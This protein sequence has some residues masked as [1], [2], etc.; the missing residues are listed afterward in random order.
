MARMVQPLDI[1]SDEDDDSSNAGTA[2]ASGTFT[3]SAVC[4]IATVDNSILPSRRRVP[5]GSTALAVTPRPRVPASQTGSMLAAS[6]QKRLSSFS[7]EAQSSGGAIATCAMCFGTS[8]A[9]PSAVQHEIY[10]MPS[11]VDM[12]NTQAYHWMLA[13]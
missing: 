8:Q 3:V 5:A 4:P 1:P 2:S 13:L 12:H 7:P 11:A 6:S 9:F 10:L